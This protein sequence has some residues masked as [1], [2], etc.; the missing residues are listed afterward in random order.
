MLISIAPFE[1]FCVFSLIYTLDKLGITEAYNFSF[2]V[3]TNNFHDHLLLR[4]SP[5]LRYEDKGRKGKLN[6]RHPTL[7]IV[8]RALG[9]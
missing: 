7:G 6:N 8:P 4:V 3:I 1:I 9:E 2:L 5:T